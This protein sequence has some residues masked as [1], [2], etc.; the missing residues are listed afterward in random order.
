MGPHIGLY[1]FSEA[2]CGGWKRMTRPILGVDVSVWN[3]MSAPTWYVG[4]IEPLL[5]R[6]VLVPP[7][8]LRAT[9]QP[10]IELAATQRST[11]RSVINLDYS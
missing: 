5:S 1:S 9:P 4:S 6:T 10:S 3:S 8:P 11:W 7:Q 2:P